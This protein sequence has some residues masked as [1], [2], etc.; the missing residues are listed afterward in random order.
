MAATSLVAG[1]SRFSR[2]YNREAIVHITP[3]TRLVGWRG[4][5]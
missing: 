2:F 5:G 4:D 1:D 3:A